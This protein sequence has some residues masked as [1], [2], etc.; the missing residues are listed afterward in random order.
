MNS[1]CKKVIKYLASFIPDKTYLK[2]RF[3][4]KM[5]KSLNLSDPKTFNEKINWLK[6]YNRNPLYTQMVDKYEMRKYVSEKI[7]EQYVV[8]LLGVWDTFDEID[9]DELP[10][11]FVLKCNHDSGSYVICTDKKNL[12]K[13]SAK[14]RIEDA[15]K[16]NYYTGYREW[17]YKNVNK[18]IIAEPY[19]SYIGID[20]RL[21]MF[22]GE[23]KFVECFLDGVT[24]R[25]VNLYLPDWTY[26]PVVHEYP[27]D[28]DYQ[29]EKPENFE[30]M[31]EIATVLSKDISLLR[32]DL[33][34]IDGQIYVNEFTFFPNAGVGQFQPEEW[35]EKI[36]SWLVLPK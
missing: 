7:G 35:D 9:F 30:E 24:D 19:L 3:R 1:Q 6:L 28:K 22:N 27:I 34:S 31:V 5:K 23:L 12:D 10:D 33:W 25:R 15:L 36:G 26:L 21:F 8:P 14:I 20:Y 18:K 13:K 16:R 32:V 2:M 11:K 29:V 17:A 4:L